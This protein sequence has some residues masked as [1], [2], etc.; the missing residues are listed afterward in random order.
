[1][2]SCA[3]LLPIGQWPC[4]RCHSAGTGPLCGTHARC[5]LEW[6]LDFTWFLAAKLRSLCAHFVSLQVLS[7]L[8]CASGRFSGEAAATA[9]DVFRQDSLTV[10]QYRLQDS[11]MCVHGDVARFRAHRGAILQFP[12]GRR[13]EAEQ[14]Y[15][16][17]YVPRECEKNCGACTVSDPPVC[18]SSSVR[19][20][21]C[22]WCLH[23]SQAPEMM[24]S[25]P[26]S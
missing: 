3:R 4:S 7:F 11:P 10:H 18:T 22:P 17:K 15:A 8:H 21:V 5:G 26:C 2:S 12:L 19:F 14:L 23:R 6:R 1:M 24:Q 9:F 20:L 16:V 13:H 25:E